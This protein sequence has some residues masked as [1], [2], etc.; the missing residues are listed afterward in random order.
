MAIATSYT[1]DPATIA[2]I[3]P[4]V[5]GRSTTDPLRA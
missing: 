2:S 4:R 1:V 3:R 5:T